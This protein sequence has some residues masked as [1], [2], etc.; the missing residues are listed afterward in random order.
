MSIKKLLTSGLLLASVVTLVA[1]GNSGNDSSASSSE[2]S[3]SKE[4]SSSSSEASSTAATLV[5]GNYTAEGEYDER[6]YK[7]VHTITVKDGKITESKFDYSKEDGQLKSEDQEYNDNM[8]SKAGVSAAEAIEELNAQLVE[9]QDV[10]KV[11]VVS[12]ASGTTDDFVKSIEAFL[13]AAAEGNTET[14]KLK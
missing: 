2:A 6:G 13:A 8:K 4:A 1:C 14:V 12:G 9:T 10:S 11:E 7:I 3:S 5:D